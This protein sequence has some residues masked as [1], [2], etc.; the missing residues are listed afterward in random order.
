M[1]SIKEKKAFKAQ[2][3]KKQQKAA[4]EAHDDFTEVQVLAAWDAYSNRL[5]KKG[6]KILASI[7][8]TDRPKI[9]GTD[10]CITL[11]NDT[12][13]TEL[14][15]SQN[16]LMAFIKRKINNTDIKL[17]IT[18]NKEAAK[19]YAFTPREKYEKLKEK[20]P[21]VETLKNTFDLD[22]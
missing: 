17:K 1:K 4:H 22:I 18:V 21:L 15:R 11:P 13:K 20:N 8:D 12:M 14:E 9:E 16:K 3:Q 6:R 10:I 7:L 5:K 19:K 2:Q